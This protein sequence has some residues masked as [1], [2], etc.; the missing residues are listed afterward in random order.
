MYIPMS[1]N[2]TRKLVVDG[3]ELKIR[4]FTGENEVLYFDKV[5]ESDAS[6]SLRD[7]IKISKDI[8]N[9]FVKGYKNPETG[10]EINFDGIGLPSSHFGQVFINQLIGSLDKA[11]ILTE[12][13]KKI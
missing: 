2:E 5:D 13:E 10:A 12:E 1:E 7:K 8:F 3:V 11:N 4:P 6:E 9:F